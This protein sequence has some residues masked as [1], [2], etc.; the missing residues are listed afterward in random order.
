MEAK[1]GV[2]TG[3][4]ATRLNREEASERVILLLE[5]YESQIGTAPTGRRYQDCYELTTGKPGKEYV[6]LYSE[7]KE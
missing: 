6:R 2:E 7:V 5:K 4:A 3:L 1:F